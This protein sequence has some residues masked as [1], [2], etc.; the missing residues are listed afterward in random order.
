MVKKRPILFLLGL[1]FI[2]HTAWSAQSVDPYQVEV[3]ASGSLS[4]DQSEAFGQ[5]MLRV[6]GSEEV[7]TNPIVEKARRHAGNYL[8]QYAYVRHDGQSVMT[9]EFNRGQIEKILTEAKVPYWGIQRPVIIIWAVEEQA[10]GQRQFVTDGSEMAQQLQNEAHHFALPVMLP[11]MDLDDSMVIRS[12]DIWGGFNQPVIKASQRYSADIALTIKKYQDLDQSEVTDW[13][14]IDL[15]SS[16]LLGSG[17]LRVKPQEQAPKQAIWSDVAQHLAEHFAVL[18][19][20]TPGEPIELTF[21]QV[22]D[23]AQYHQL[24]SFLAEQPSVGNMRV[25]SVDGER[26]TL[27]LQLLGQWSELQHALELEPEFTQDPH[28][29]YLYQREQ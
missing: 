4:A 26:Y 21:T 22:K 27:S 19:S 10:N 11:V 29:P 7:L 20:D 12:S 17:E 14:L 9:A 28:N 18:R 13:Q 23:F 16:S 3:P 24:T 5:L 8:Q 25:E 2:C 6:T 1:L 15:R